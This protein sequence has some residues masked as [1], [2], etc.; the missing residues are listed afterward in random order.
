MRT[1]SKDETE[2]T[3]ADHEDDDEKEDGG[4]DDQFGDGLA[5]FSTCPAGCISHWH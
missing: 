4:D 3:D 1:R 2:G 5:L